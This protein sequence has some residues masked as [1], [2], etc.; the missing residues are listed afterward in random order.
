MGVAAAGPVIGDVMFRVRSFDRRHSLELLVKG[1][2]QCRF[3]IR[4]TGCRIIVVA[5][6]T[7]ADSLDVH[8]AA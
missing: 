4:L 1:E 8:A 2:D 3:G 5:P 7:F 6:R